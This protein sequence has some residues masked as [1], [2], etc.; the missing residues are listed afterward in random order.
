MAS[1][2]PFDVLRKKLGRFTLSDRSFAFLYQPDTSGEVVSLDCETTGLDPLV[3][4]IISICAIKIRGARILTSERFEVLVRPDSDRPRTK[5]VPIHRLRPTD[6]A[7]GLPIDEAV[8]QLLH[9]VGSRP[10]VGYYLEFD[11]LMLDKYLFPMLNILL[12]N[13]L[14]EV[15]GMYYDLVTRRTAGHEIDLRFASIV[16]AL[17]LPMLAAHDAC[18]DALMAA[19]IYLRLLGRQA[20]P[21]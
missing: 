5:G 17:D 18:N 10:L 8:R 14:I 19:M 13:R 20:L 11:V 2:T 16:Q 7:A 1:R 21:A 4:D 6:L 15:S 12:P 9:F 3:D